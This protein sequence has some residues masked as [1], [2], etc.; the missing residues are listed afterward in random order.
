MQEHLGILRP[1]FR[2][3]PLIILATMIGFVV[4][5]KYLN[6]VTPMYESTTTL[7]LADISEGVN[8]SNLF[9][10]FDVFATSN[11]IAGEIEVL[12]SQVL[13]NKVLD[14]LNFDVEISD[15]IDKKLA[16]TL[17]F[18]NQEFPIKLFTNKRL[19]FSFCFNNN[20]FF[21]ANSLCF[22]FK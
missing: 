20:L 11:K 4:A 10:D 6:Y 1:Y 12:K 18:S 17:L 22:F 13:L 7:K 2:G 15:L 21:T 9:K 14:E 19:F 8:N 16:T 3:L 5:S